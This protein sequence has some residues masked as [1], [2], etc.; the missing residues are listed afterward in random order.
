MTRAVVR[1]FARQPHGLFASR[2]LSAHL[3][4]GAAAAALLAGAFV[5]Q[6][7]H[8]WWAA[9]AALAALGALRGCPVCWTIGLVETLGRQRRR[10]DGRLRALP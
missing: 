10:G 7:A 8:P 9:A 1:F 6:S 3:L 5:L 2:H 4:R